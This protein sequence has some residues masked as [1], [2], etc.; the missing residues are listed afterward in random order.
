MVHR[1]VQAEVTN[2][3]PI[4]IVILRYEGCGRHSVLRLER[5]GEGAELAASTPKC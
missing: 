2:I 1:T 5:R 4:P 3:D